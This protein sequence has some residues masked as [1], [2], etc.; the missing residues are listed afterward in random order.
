MKTKRFD[1]KF[2]AGDTIVEQLDLSQA[3]RVGSLAKR[4]NVDFPAWMV[5][6]LDREARRVGVTRQALIKLW[7]ADRLGQSS[8]GGRS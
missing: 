6:S 2:D 5:D 7:L 8:S 1:Q 3:R 4:V